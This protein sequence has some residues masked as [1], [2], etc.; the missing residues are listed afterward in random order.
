MSKNELPIAIIGAGPVG[1]AAAAHCVARGAT[2]IV[3]EAGSS[4]GAS[5]LAWGQVRIFSPWRYDIDAAA[6]ALL[7]GTGWSAPD[8]DGYPTGRELVE[9]YLR[10]LAETPQI[11][12]HL[13]L[14]HRVRSVTRLGH[15]KAKT[16]G[17]EDAP[18]VLAVATPAGE[19]QI[20]ARAV[21]DA[22]GTST[23][24]NPIGASGTPA[25]G[26]ADAAT[27][28]VY[29]IPDVLGSSRARYEGRR[30]L[31]VGA[32][33]SAFNVLIDLATLAE[34]EPR[35]RVTWVVRRPFADAKYGGAADDAL[36]ARGA[37]GTRM[38]VLVEQGAIRQEVL[39]TSTLR[40]T[41]DGVFVADERRELGPFDEIVA[42]TG[43]RPDLQPLRELRVRLDDILEAPPALS[44]LIDPNVHSCGTVPP[45]GAREL[46]HP[47][48]DLYIAGMKS[49]G[50]APTF[51]MLT[52][53]E[54]VR[55]I[56]SALVGDTAGAERVQL[57]LPQTGVCSGGPG[58]ACCDEP[59]SDC[60]SPTSGCCGTNDA[61]LSVASLSV[62]R[63]R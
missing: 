44:P 12:P 35:T 24:P 27:R 6:R 55:S 62:P 39:R 26:E 31:V 17:R 57:V 32:G 51:L 58:S 8:G 37:L 9:R 63:G 10:P 47:E 25:R 20:L 40:T 38:R 1:L 19:Q 23:L 48:R 18:F 3:L 13:R 21:I 59:A 60:G 4:V 46:A 28:I 34:Q 7:E 53:Y 52:G 61:L 11:A 56:V 45:H 5:V 49:Y 41:S 42:V 2:P 22:S 43:S 14:D 30:V 15:D 54:Q 50:R 36:P 29:G 33:H 16:A